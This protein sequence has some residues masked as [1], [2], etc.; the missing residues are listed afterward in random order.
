MHKLTTWLKNVNKFCKNV[1]TANMYKFHLLK[2]LL[3]E[4]IGIIV[5]HCLGSLKK[6]KQNCTLHCNLD[7]N[8]DLSTYILSKFDIYFIYNRV[9]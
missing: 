9:T 6:K 3:Y 1:K 2:Y 5:Q 7:Y 8:H 4:S